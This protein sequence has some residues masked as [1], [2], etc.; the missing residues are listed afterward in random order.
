M[1]KKS[2]Q[3]SPPPPPPSSTEISSGTKGN[4]VILNGSRLESYCRELLHSRFTFSTT[5][6]GT[7]T[8]IHSILHRPTFI[9]S[10]FLPLN[11]IFWPYHM[12]T[13]CTNWWSDFCSNMRLWIAK[14][15]A[16]M[17]L[18][19]EPPRDV[20][21][22][23]SDDTRLQQPSSRLIEMKW[24]RKNL[25]IAEIPLVETHLWII[26]RGSN[27]EVSR[28]VFSHINFVCTFRTL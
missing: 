13:V 8:G 15:A 5:L 10:L 23:W 11:S 18:K 24:S 3:S 7:S 21:S 12:W 14:T 26:I 20:M 6:K 17:L 19:K 9:L 25:Y 22:A 1:L 28:H 2:V 4:C 16:N 27:V